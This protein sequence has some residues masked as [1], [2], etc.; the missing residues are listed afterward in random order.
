[1]ISECEQCSKEISVRPSELA[2]GNGKF[3]SRKCYGLSKRGKPSSRAGSGKG[4]LEKPCQVCGKTFYYWPSQ[5]KYSA[6]KFCSHKCARSIRKGVN[7]P[8]WKDGLKKT[9]DGYVQIHSPYHPNATSGYVLRSRLIAEKHLC[10]FLT[11]NE[12]IHH[13]NG[14]KDDDRPENLYLFE[15]QAGHARY[16]RLVKSGKV[17]EIIASNLT[18]ICAQ[19]P[20]SQRHRYLRL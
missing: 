8:C 13:I 2:K 11:K 9:K 4:K 7:A 19:R 20:E 12:V 1:M 16:H 15:H 3:C 14:I 17:D 6:M 5:A 10:R 18:T